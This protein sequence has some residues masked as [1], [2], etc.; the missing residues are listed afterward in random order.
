VDGSNSGSCRTARVGIEVSQLRVL[1]SLLSLI[2]N[3]ISPVQ[4]QTANYYCGAAANYE[5]WP[6]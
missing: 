1:S 5:T 2:S 4:Q 3:K 6:F